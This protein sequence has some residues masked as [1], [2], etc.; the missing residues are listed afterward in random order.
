MP[1]FP[2]IIC[3]K[4][5]TF[6]SSSVNPAGTRTPVQMGKRMLVFSGEA[7]STLYVLCL[8]GQTE[9]KGVTT[10]EVEVF[11]ARLL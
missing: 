4:T 5:S 8:S 3:K 9:Q 7:A 2:A 1:A 6:G 11:R 10:S